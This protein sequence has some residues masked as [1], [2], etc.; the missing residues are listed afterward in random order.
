MPAAP[1]TLRR[2]LLPSPSAPLPLQAL[3]LCAW[4]L[5]DLMIKEAAF[6]ALLDAYN[7]RLSAIL[8]TAMALVILTSQLPFRLAKVHCFVRTATWFFAAASSGALQVG[9]CLARGTRVPRGA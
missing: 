2:A 6:A 3:L 1:P 9:P 7:W 5:S 8:M 4:V